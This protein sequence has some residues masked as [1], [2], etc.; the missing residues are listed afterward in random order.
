M[1]AV[2]P[3]RLDNQTR[4]MSVHDMAAELDMELTAE[5]SR[6]IAN[7]LILVSSDLNLP[8][9]VKQ[10]RT[11]K[12]NPDYERQ[13]KLHAADNT[14]P[15]PKRRIC[16]S[17]RVKSFDSQTVYYFNQLCMLLDIRI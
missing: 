8:V 9:G 10:H 13:V 12:A 6:V 1:L 15:K 2:P 7:A 17:Y 3:N 4:L 5:Q 14:L 16:Q 11:S